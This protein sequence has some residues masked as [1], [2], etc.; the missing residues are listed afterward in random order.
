VLHIG[1]RIY[2]TIQ[3][4]IACAKK[5]LTGSALEEN[6]TFYKLRKNYCGFSAQETAWNKKERRKVIKT[7]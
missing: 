4:R 1:R 5:K 7:C 6:T 3:F 2:L